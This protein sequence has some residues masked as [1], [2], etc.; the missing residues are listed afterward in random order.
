MADLIYTPESQ[1]II[2]HEPATIIVELGDDSVLTR[3]KA[4]AFWREWFMEFNG[5]DST[6]T[7]AIMDLFYSHG[8]DLTLTIV[9]GDPREAAAT[10]ATVLFGSRPGIDQSSVVATFS[11]HFRQA[12]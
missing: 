10:E 12:L 11:V 3:R 2:Y 9:T 6:V 7:D 1:R 4:T 5:E 8:L